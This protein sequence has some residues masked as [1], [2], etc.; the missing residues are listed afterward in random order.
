MFDASR[1]RQIFDQMIHQGYPVPDWWRRKHGVPFNTPP[2]AT[3]GLSDMALPPYFSFTRHIR[4]MYKLFIKAF[5]LRNDRAAAKV[6]IG[7]LK[8]VE[9]QHMRESETRNRVRREG[10]IKKGLK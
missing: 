9:I 3:S 5:Y 1:V 8:M 7:I 6:I 2:S 4:P 10:I